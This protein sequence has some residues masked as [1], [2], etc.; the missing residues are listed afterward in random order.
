M[1][2]RLKPRLVSKAEIWWLHVSP[3]GFHAQRYCVVLGCMHV[4]SM[5]A[6]AAR[7]HPE[8]V[9]HQSQE[10]YPCR[11]SAAIPML[12]CPAIQPTSRVL[13]GTSSRPASRPIFGRPDI[14]TQPIPPPHRPHSVTAVAAS[15]NRLQL[16]KKNRS[17]LL[18]RCKF[19][20]CFFVMSSW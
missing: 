7:E 1:V 17:H 10:A 6:E 19:R 11:I 4:A 15:S 2:D 3:L 16:V 12:H 20:R 18:E 9:E 5:V 13:K 14:L 8:E